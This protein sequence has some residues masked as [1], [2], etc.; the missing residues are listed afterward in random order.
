MN[1]EYEAIAKKYGNMTHVNSHDLMRCA[2]LDCAE[3]A[4]KPQVRL[5]VARL[6]SIYVV[7]FGS[8]GEGFSAIQEEILAAQREPVEVPFDFE[9]WQEGGWQIFGRDG[10]EVHINCTGDT[11]TMRRK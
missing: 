1:P 5:S 10:K 7:A 8:N 9:K 3:L 11:Y 2:I 4:N 6:K